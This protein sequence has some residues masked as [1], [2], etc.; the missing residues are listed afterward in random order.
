MSNIALTVLILLFSTILSPVS[1]SIWDL[2]FRGPVVSRDPIVSRGPIPSNSPSPP[3]RCDE[4][5]EPFWD[6]FTPL[7]SK[8]GTLSSALNQT[9]AGKKALQA[10]VIH[11][12]GLDRALNESEPKTGGA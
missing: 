12:E 6:P 10:L 9:V 8:H 7:G 3:G 11:F 2:L 5:T 4:E 1:S